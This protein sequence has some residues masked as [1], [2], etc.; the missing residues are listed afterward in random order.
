MATTTA[1]RPIDGTQ[2]IVEQEAAA[3]GR[4]PCGGTAAR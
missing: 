2:G 3:A 1:A 4:L